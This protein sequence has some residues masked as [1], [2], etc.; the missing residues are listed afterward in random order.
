ML[1]SAILDVAIGLIFV[2]LLLSLICS[3]CAEGIESIFKQRAKFLEAG[4][5]R[6]LGD[7]AGRFF[8]HALI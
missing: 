1:G 2:Y 3:S 7:L 6:M 8:G 4:I 5:Q